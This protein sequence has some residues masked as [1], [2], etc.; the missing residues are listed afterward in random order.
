MAEGEAF[1]PAHFR[2][3]KKDRPKQEAD[4]KTDITLDVEDHAQAQNAQ[5]F[6]SLLCTLRKGNTALATSTVGD[7]SLRRC[8]FE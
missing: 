7:H 4:V 5:P 8:V 6:C 2:E 1:V 3:T